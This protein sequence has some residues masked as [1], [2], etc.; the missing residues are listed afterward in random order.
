MQLVLKYL[1]FILI[2]TLTD[3]RRILSPTSSS[4]LT[5]DDISHPNSLTVVKDGRIESA[6]SLTP[7]H[8]RSNMPA[9]DCRESWWRNISTRLE[10]CGVAK[11][12]SD[13][14]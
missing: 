4:E 13:W 5:I 6:E 2:R 12:H 9:F 11:R 10:R 1:H 14:A 8:P 7:F 3:S